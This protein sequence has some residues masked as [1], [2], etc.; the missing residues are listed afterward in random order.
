MVLLAYQHQPAAECLDT[1]G[2][3]RLGC[4]QIRGVVS[5]TPAILQPPA[6]PC[7]AATSSASPP[8]TSSPLE[9][10]VSNTESSRVALLQGQSHKLALPPELSRASP[11]SGGAFHDGSAPP[12]QSLLTGLAHRLLLDA[13][14]LA[15]AS[16]TPCLP[17]TALSQWRS[18]APQHVQRGRGW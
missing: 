12:V 14:R 2:F 17:P 3:S 10:S 9:T 8:Q 13:H 4:A 7:S 5:G 18:L 11:A 16:Q 1:S 6:L 15:R